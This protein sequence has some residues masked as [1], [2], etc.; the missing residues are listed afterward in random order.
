MEVKPKANEVI[1]ITG[2]TASGKSQIAL[3]LAKKYQGIIINADSMQIYKEIPI[4]TASPSLQDKSDAPHFL[5]NFIT[6]KEKYDV[7]SWY[8]AVAKIIKQYLKQNTPIIVVG[9]T[10]LYIS[11]MIGGIAPIPSIL[12][13]TKNKYKNTSVEEM[14]QYLLQENEEFNTKLPPTDTHRITRAF[15]IKKQTGKSL[16]FWQKQQHIKLLECDFRVFMVTEN[17]DKIKKNAQKRFDM[18]LKK[19]ALEEAK[20]IQNM[21]IPLENLKAL[22]LKELI[23]YLNGNISLQEAKEKT[24]IKTN[25]YI[26]RQCTWFKNNHYTKNAEQIKQ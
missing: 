24:I 1:V 11:T 10:G 23:S 22:G 8:Q 15:L 3:N 19:G 7:F 13:D 20:K 14:N 17:R 26:K 9:G 21:N 18:M 2:P 12:E 5:Y 16:A 4:I 25:Q 6:I